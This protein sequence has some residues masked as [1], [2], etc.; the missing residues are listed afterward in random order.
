[1]TAIGSS[2][3]SD[4]S[5]AHLR[6]KLEQ[7]PVAKSQY[8]R[9]VQWLDRNSVLGVSRDEKGRI[10]LFLS[11]PRLDCSFDNVAI[12]LAHDCWHGD[13]QED[14]VANRL[15]LPAEGYFNAVG[16]F[17]C[18]NLLENGVLEN[19]QKGF[20]RSE[21]VI[22]LVL[23]KSRLQNELLVGLCGELLVMRALLAAHA[24]HTHDVLESWHGHV[25]S[26]RDY[27]FAGV[28]VEV[29]TT[30][31]SVSRHRI[32]GI[33]QIELGHP[34]GGGLETHLYLI[35]I[36]VTNTEVG[37]AQANAWTLPGLV[38]D[39]VRLIRESDAPEQDRLEGQFL[40]RLQN[41]G[42]TVS[43]YDHRQME[44]RI[45]FAQ[46]Y[47]TSFVRSYD[48]RDTAIMVP[49]TSDLA[50]FTAVDSASLE[51]VMDL[52][53]QV[54]GDLNPIVGLREALDEVVLRA[55]SAS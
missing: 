8:E 41:Y 3:P 25:R 55:W 15:L 7:L 9:D 48:M 53:A 19:V 11:G 28:G 24:E 2:D 51:F 42:G 1:M 4:V 13:N 16:A 5:Y 36:G 49:R 27:Q 54:H 45:A 17:L 52:P 50:R 21:A 10:E 31:G 47:A 30:R 39:V 44:H 12:N 23:D 40:E 38:D 20:S 34:V 29:K 18:A 14:V 35:S 6:G 32:H 43:G 37:A 22:S 46:P 33:R 26:S